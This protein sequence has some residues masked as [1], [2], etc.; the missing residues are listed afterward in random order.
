MFLPGGPPVYRLRY[1]TR[2][3]ILCRDCGWLKLAP[4]VK[5]G[6]VI[7]QCML[8]HRAAEFIRFP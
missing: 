3:E 8:R 2:I 4:D 1:L 5:A 7:G 6:T